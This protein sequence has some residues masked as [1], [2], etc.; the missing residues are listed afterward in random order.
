MDMNNSGDQVVT[1]SADHGLR[2]YNLRTGKQV[3]QLYNK[4][5]GHSDW[6]TTCAFLTDGRVVS[7]SMDNRLFLW[8]KS[9]V[10][11]TDLVGHNGSISK[12]KVDQNNVAISAGYDSSLLVWTLDTK[13]CAN[14]LFNGHKQ[15][16]MDFE[17]NNSLAV[18]GDKA[19][20][21]AFWDI[22]RSDPVKTLKA[23]GSAV[24][25][26]TLYSDDKN[27]NLVLTSGLRDGKVN[28]FD[29]RTSKVVKSAMVHRG[30]IN[31]MQV[32]DNTGH[33]ITG[34]AD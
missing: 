5:Y 11:C 16:V 14:G 7:G 21:L 18:S 6:V 27:Q 17:W 1:A 10:K 4:R 13:E 15:A 20:G 2:L 28:I 30:A 34:S 22:N 31:F 25:K 23:H 33:I 32:A 8:D 9:A 24:G 3:R 12:V 19:G 26:I 29:M